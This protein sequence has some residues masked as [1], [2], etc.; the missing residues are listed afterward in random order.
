[1][2]KSID[3]KISYDI[4][5]ITSDD[6]SEIRKMIKDLA[7]LENLGSQM[8]QTDDDIRNHISNNILKGFIV[9]SNNN[10]VG[11]LIYYTSY[12]SWKGPFYFLEDI[13]VK[14]EYRKHNIGKQLFNRLVEK[15]RENNIKK[16]SWHVLKWNEPAVKFYQK[17]GAEDLTETEDRHVL[18]LNEY[19]IQNFKF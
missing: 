17:L 5:T 2:I 3:G 18:N 4:K 6:A 10:V 12:S 16:I 14:S 8:E 15:A 19:D 9:I 7:D 1:M 13:Y 11:M